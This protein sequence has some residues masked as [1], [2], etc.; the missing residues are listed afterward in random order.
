MVPVHKRGSKSNPKN[1]RPIFL[2]SVVGKVFERVVADVICRHLKEN[3]LLSDQQFG[4]RPGRSSSDLL[5]LL[6][7]DWQSSFDDAWTLSW[8]P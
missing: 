8:S 7:R 1:Y 6:T 4:F 5:M 2:L 3:Y